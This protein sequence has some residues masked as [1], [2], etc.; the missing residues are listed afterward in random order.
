MQTDRSQLL[1]YLDKIARYLINEGII[2]TDDM[3]NKEVLG[4]V[5]E[6]VTA[7]R[8]R[9]QSLLT[10][11]RMAQELNKRGGWGQGT[12]FDVSVSELLQAP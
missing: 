6:T 12:P 8:A 9:E 5:V 10:A 11:L 1:E 7:L 4:Y 2:K 3:T